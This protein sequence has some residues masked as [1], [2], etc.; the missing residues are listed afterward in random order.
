MPSLLTQTPRATPLLLGVVHLA[1]LPGSPRYQG[2]MAEVIAAAV[3][4]A[5]ALITGGMDGYIVENFG[6]TP[7]FPETTPPE[8]VAAMA[9]VLSALPRPEGPVGVNVLRNDARAAFTLA[10]KAPYAVGL[11]FF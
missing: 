9:R 10:Q 6:D 8:T 11:G 1:P 2:Q 5:E 3:K 7:F 4:D